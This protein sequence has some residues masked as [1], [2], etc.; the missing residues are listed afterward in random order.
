VA[1]VGSG[2]AVAA[3]VLDQESAVSP[4]G[5]AYAVAVPLTAF[6][7]VLA[8]LHRRAGKRLS[9]GRRNLVKALGV[10]V[11]A[12]SVVV[13]PLQVTVLLLGVYLGLCVAD[14]GW[15]AARARA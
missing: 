7:I 9:L 8:E 1:A 14:N 10:L 11:V 12:A 6:L 13:V 4:V 5:A 3:E 15:A 2:L